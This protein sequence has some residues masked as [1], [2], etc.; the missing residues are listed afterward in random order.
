M[1][2]RDLGIPFD[3]TPGPTNSIL[4]IPGIEV[5]MVTLIDGDGPLVLDK[6]PVRTGVTAILPVGKK[7]IRKAVPA[8]IFSLNG[9]GEMT[10][11]HWIKETGGLSGPIMLTNTHALGTVHRGVI[12]WTKQNHPEVAIEWLLPVVAETWDGYL[13]DINGPH[14]TT[15]HAVVAIDN[16]SRATIQEGSFGGG[17][18]MNCYGYKG[19]NGT[20]SRQV[21]FGG[22]SY[23]VASFMQ[24]NFGD[25]DELRIAGVSMRG[26]EVPHPM[27][28]K[29]W[30]ERD[31]A[32]FVP[33]GSGSVIAVIATDAPLLPNQC[34]ALARR[35]SLGLARTGTTGGHFSGDIFIAFSTAGADALSSGFPDESARTAN[36]Q[37]LE[38][39]PWNYMDR[40]YKATVEVVEE[41]IVNALV[42]NENMVGRDGNVSYALPHELLVNRLSQA[43]LITNS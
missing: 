26:L 23:T 20:A 30:L 8:A 16:A 33:G 34:E 42:C 6:G 18:G 25:R 7:D 35:V 15:Q 36:L 4:D 2:A 21:D 10:G 19:G 32:R 24:C 9:N 29:D 14:V 43:N 17:T 38:F 12:E 28:E 40:F 39:V 27:G 37:Q 31:K 5:G 13:N 1:R 22:K 41:A 11:S 3:G